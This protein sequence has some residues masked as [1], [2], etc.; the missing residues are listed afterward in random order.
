[1]PIMPG[2]SAGLV[3]HQNTCPNEFQSHALTSL[4]KRVGLP[5]D[6][7]LDALRAT[8]RVGDSAGH[9]QQAANLGSEQMH[10]NQQARQQ[11]LR[12]RSY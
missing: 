3:V 7:K 1:M 4:L 11:P 2:R 8:C 6:L 12:W 10:H 5:V 9:I